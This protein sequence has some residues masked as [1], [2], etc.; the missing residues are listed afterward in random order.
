MALHV[1]HTLS[2]TLQVLL[3]HDGG[4]PASGFDQR[5]NLEK[6]LSGNVSFRILLSFYRNTHLI[7]LG[8]VFSHLV[9]LNLQKMP[10]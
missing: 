1:T 7:G 4:V 10:S 3:L 9:S 2:F 6:T 8:L 5:R